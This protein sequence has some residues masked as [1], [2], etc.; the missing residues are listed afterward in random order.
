MEA[1]FMLLGSTALAGAASG[2][3]GIVVAA[4]DQTRRLKPVKPEP[5]AVSVELVDFPGKLEEAFERALEKQRPLPPPIVDLPEPDWHKEMVQDMILANDRLATAAR[6]LAK[7]P[8][9]HLEK[10]VAALLESSIRLEELFATPSAQPVADEYLDLRKLVRELAE[11]VA[12][13]TWLPA[14]F[15]DLFIRLGQRNSTVTTPPP[16][17]IAGGGRALPPARKAPPTPRAAPPPGPNMNTPSIPAPYVGGSVVVPANEATSL[18]ALIQ[19][20]LQPN[21]PGG[22]AELVLSADDAVFVGSASAI[23]GPLSETN[24]A[25]QLTPGGPPRIYRSS[26]PG[27]QAPLADLQVFAAAAAVLHVEVTT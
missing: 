19:Q 26:F 1:S 9:E 15:N 7:P 20:Q 2:I 12:P 17:L 25:F 27:N 14:Q 18:F 23:G 16:T 10:L 8:S 5:Q 21:C 24:Y 3:W 22:A 4:R 11:A 13:L 6:Q